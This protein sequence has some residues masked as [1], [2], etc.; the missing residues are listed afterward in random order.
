VAPTR[1]DFERLCLQIENELHDGFAWWGVDISKDPPALMYLLLLL[2]PAA[3]YLNVWV[4]RGQPAWV[5]A[6]LKFQHEGKDDK[7]ARQRG[8]PLTPVSKRSRCENEP[9]LRG[10]AWK[11]ALEFLD[12][13]FTPIFRSLEEG[14]EAE[15]ARKKGKGK[16]KGSWTAGA[17]KGGD[18]S[19][20]G[21][22][23]PAGESRLQ[24]QN[25]LNIFVTNLGSG[26]EEVIS[27]V[28][29]KQVLLRRS[30]VQELFLGARA[31]FF[32]VF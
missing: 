16:G 3:R 25:S 22:S 2:H 7:H 26:C 32:E 28:K 18:G 23:P 6:L 10:Y 1:N 14:E 20:G 31:A 9:K 4:C 21:V 29:G 11:V 8:A 17:G 27:T 15:G 19:G 13:F 24:R 30:A 5:H 12:D